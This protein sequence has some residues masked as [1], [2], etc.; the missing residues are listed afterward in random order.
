M[1]HGKT[2]RRRATEPSFS[3]SDSGAGAEAKPI[4][5]A[6]ANN[7]GER[8]TILPQTLDQ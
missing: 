6:D 7:S 4:K 1:A 2:P 8:M 3:V 5:F